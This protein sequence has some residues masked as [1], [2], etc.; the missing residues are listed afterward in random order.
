VI[1]GD[2]CLGFDE[3]SWSFRQIHDGAGHL[4]PA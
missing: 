1:R 2:A 4:K 3:R